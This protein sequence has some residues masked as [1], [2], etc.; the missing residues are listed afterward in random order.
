M[1]LG[2]VVAYFDERSKCDPKT[3]CWEWT[4][5][6]LRSGYGTCNVEGIKTVAHR[7]QFWLVFGRIERGHEIHHKC[8]NPACI[9]PD[10]LE[11]LSVNEHARI[12]Q[13]A[14][15][16]HCKHGHEFTPQNTYRKVSNGTRVC[17]ACAAN[18]QREMRKSK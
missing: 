2:R 5:S 1:N 15:Q 9:N 18:R 17:R 12:G 10:H 6:R 14:L 11:S 8:H 13:K 16:T 3:G 4:G 7:A